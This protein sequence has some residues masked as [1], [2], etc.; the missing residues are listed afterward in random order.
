MPGEVG[1]FAQGIAKEQF[2]AHGLFVVVGVL[3][4]R[5]VETYAHAELGI[6]VVWVPEGR[7][8]VGGLGADG[9]L[10]AELVA[11]A[12]EVALQNLAR[13]KDLRIAGIA[14]AG[15]ELARGFFLDLDPQVEGLGAAR[16]LGRDFHGFE[17]V[18]FGQ[19]A[20]DRRSMA[21]L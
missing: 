18:E 17:K 15:R 19:G 9:A 10:E 5:V 1:V 8:V 16:G 21:P 11:H 7:R 12:E 13:E 14:D 4:D 2:A 3:V 6:V 20:F